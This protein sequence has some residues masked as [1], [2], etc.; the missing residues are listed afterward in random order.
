MDS[1]SAPTTLAASV[2]A[3]APASKECNLQT[4]RDLLIWQRWLGSPDTT[5]QVG[6][7]DIVNC[8][9]TLDN[10]RVGQPANAGYCSKIAW[11]DDN[12]GYDDSARPAAP[13][14]KVLDEIGPAC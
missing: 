10:W 2:P 1:T 12:P 13:L 11:A 14:K 7:V 3:S 5:L 6:D 8:V 4:A 9:P